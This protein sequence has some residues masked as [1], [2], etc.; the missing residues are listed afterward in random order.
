MASRMTSRG[1]YDLG[2]NLYI[3]HPG[4]DCGRALSSLGTWALSE[5]EMRCNFHLTVAEEEVEVTF[6]SLAIAGE[7]E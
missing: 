4:A 1:L 3:L 7:G 2:G 5:H 6:G